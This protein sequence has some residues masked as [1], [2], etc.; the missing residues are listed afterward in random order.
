MNIVNPQGNL[1]FGELQNGATY[2]E[3]YLPLGATLVA[4]TDGEGVRFE[5]DG[6]FV[7][8]EVYAPLSLSGDVQGAVNPF[9]LTPGQHVLRITRFATDAD[10]RTNR[11]PGEVTTI[12]FT[13]S[14][15]PAS[16]PGSP[17]GSTGTGGGTDPGDGTNYPGYGDGGGS[18]GGGVVGTPPVAAPG[19]IF[20]GPTSVTATAPAAAPAVPQT[21]RQSGA[22]PR[23]KPTFVINR[24]SPRGG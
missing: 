22:A 14:T 12:T 3:P 24:A 2:Y 5:Y 13:I 23:A 21:S 4:V 18:T 1:I 9:D 7:R 16:A 19:A 8:S 15:D 17:G 10:A 11:L 6:Q 20:G